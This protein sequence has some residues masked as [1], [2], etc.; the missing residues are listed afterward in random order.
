MCIL[1]TLYN[2]LLYIISLL[3]ANFYLIIVHATVVEKPLSKQ[4]NMGIQYVSNTNEN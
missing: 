4:I 2:I 3:N 1:L